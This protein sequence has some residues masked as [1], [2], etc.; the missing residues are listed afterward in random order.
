MRVALLTLLLTVAIGGSVLQA[1]EPPVF[2]AGAAT[3]NITSALGSTIIGGWMP[4]AATHIHDELHVRCL[5]LDD[6]TTQL[7]FVIV[8]N[9]GMAR[10]LF[11]EAKRRAEEKTG[12]PTHC[13]LMA[14]T[15]THSAASTRSANRYLPNQPISDYGQFIIERIVNGLACAVNNLRPAR[16][17]WATAQEPEL[18]FNRRWF[19]KPGTPMPD[20]FGG[21]DQVVFN[22]GRGNENVVKPAGPTDPQI[23]FLSVR[24]REGEPIALMANY[25][26]HYVGGVPQGHI[27]AD[28]FAIFADRIQK[29]LDADRLGPPFVGILTNGTSGDINNIDV[30]HKTDVKPHY[31]QMRLVAHRIA[32]RVAVAEEQMTYHDWVTLRAAAADLPLAT[33]RPTDEQLA[34]AKQVAADPKAVKLYSRREPIYA[35]RLLAMRDMPA[36]VHIPLTAFRVGEL[37][38]VAIPFEVFAEIGLALRSQSPLATTCTI[39]HAGG[40]FGYLPTEDQH[41][42]GGYETWLGTNYVQE[43]A[44][45]IIQKKLI[46]MLGETE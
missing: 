11:D 18:V 20:P 3:A 40:S 19:M 10:E 16:I 26:L 31:E 17:G 45:E 43:D 33:R 27:S 13:M 7:A 5:V 2:Q 30:L 29:L 8:D 4:H 46:S 1:E 28:Y 44:A 15:H 39:S 34:R 42:L 6:G 22:P 35:E 21:T 14:A 25:S 23:T 9:L 41:A 36:T 12:I 37:A 38:V 32:E 24:S